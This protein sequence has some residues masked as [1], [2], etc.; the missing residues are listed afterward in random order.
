MVGGCIYMRGDCHRTGRTRGRG[1]A[2]RLPS[3]CMR[4]LVERKAGGPTRSIWKGCSIPGCPRRRERSRVAESPSSA[5][6]V[7][8]RTR[9]R[10]CGSM[11]AEVVKG[12]VNSPPPFKLVANY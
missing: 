5:R 3:C 4:S 2:K 8:R 1:G 10:F 7:R 11:P 12:F 6:V 9:P